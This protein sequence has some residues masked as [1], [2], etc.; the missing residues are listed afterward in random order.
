[1]HLILKWAREVAVELRQRWPYIPLWY[2][3]IRTIIYVY[4]I[5]ILLI[6]INRYQLV[7]FISVHAHIINAYVAH[8]FQP[9]R[10]KRTQ[11]SVKANH[12]LTLICSFHSNLN[13]INGRDAMLRAEISWLLTADVGN[14]TDE[15]S[16]LDKYKC[17]NI[18]KYKMVIYISWI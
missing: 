11:T 10:C 7:V 13:Y 9:S 12:K 8:S 14:P 16:H 3:H 6:E 5:H 18:S 15:R 2:G 1:M 17:C 4:R